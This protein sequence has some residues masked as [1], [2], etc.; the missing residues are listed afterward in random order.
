MRDLEIRGAGNILGAQQHGHM[1]AVGYEMYLRMLS[2]AIQEQKGEKKPAQADRECQIDIR[3]GAHIPESYIDNLSQR[4]DVYKKIATIRSE[5]D[6]LDVMDELI[7]RFGEPPSSVKGLIDVALLR[8]VAA[9][10]E[11]YEISQKQDNILLFP[12]NLDFP[13]AS[14]LSGALPGRVMVSA[15]AKPYITVRIPPQTQ[16][17]DTMREALLTMKKL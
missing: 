6:S 4:I 10:M 16:P 14:R 2:D 13:R 15:G 17:I 9:S 11:I 8:N 5:E 1:E 12:Q 3:I 7:D